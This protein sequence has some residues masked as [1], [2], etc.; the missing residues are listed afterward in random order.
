MVV[1][2]E[3]IILIG[4]IACVVGIV[5]LVTK[6]NSPKTPPKISGTS[7]ESITEKTPVKPPAKPPVKT[8]V[9]PPE[10]QPENDDKPAEESVV[11][12]F[13][14]PQIA[15]RNRCRNCDGE[16]PALA[17]ICQICGKEI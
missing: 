16:N 17:R 7:R 6:L 5:V 13:D 14:D 3:F 1:T 8:P 10:K 4:I 11:I 2:M 12:I 15:G 9:K